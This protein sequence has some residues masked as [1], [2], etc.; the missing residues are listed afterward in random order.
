MGT[1][2]DIAPV[3]AAA[4]LAHRPALCRQRQSV[5]VQRPAGHV[6]GMQ[7]PRPQVG[8]DLERAFDTS[9]RSTKARFCCRIMAWMSWDWTDLHPVRAC[10]ISTRNWPDFTEQEMAS[11]CCTARLIQGQNRRWPARPLNLTFDGIVDEVQPQIHQARCQDHVRAHSKSSGA[12]Y[13]RWRLPAV[14]RR[15][16]EPGRAESA[17]STGATSPNSRPC[18]WMS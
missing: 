2:T 5:L 14:Q 1:I 3:L 6:P 12:L 17:R 10:L 18:R 9:N 4:V 11:C 13:D 16:A 8:V 7:R 15:T